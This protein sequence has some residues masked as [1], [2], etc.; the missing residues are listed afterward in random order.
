MDY[1]YTNAFP[2]D[3]SDRGED[4]MHVVF[5]VTFPCG[6]QIYHERQ[7]PFAKYLRKF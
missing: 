2:K 5:E 3:E 7:H 6:L 4:W 1:L